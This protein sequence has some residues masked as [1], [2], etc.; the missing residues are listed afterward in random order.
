[1]KNSRIIFIKFIKRNLSLTIKPFSQLKFYLI[2]NNRIY[3]D[4]EIFLKRFKKKCILL[5]ILFFLENNYFI[6]NI[7]KIYATAKTAWYFLFTIQFNF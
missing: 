7:Y 6:I 1:M 2:K 4:K 3:L 5:V